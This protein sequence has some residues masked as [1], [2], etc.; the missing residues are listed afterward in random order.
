MGAG[1]TFGVALRTGMPS[2]RMTIIP[3]FIFLDTSLAASL[4]THLSSSLPS[5]SASY[6]RQSGSQ[7]A[8]G[9]GQNSASSS[10][11]EANIKTSFICS[12]N[13][14]RICSLIKHRVRFIV[15]K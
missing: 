1:G 14:L 7:H 6:T 4:S 10:A 9:S 11:S 15:V 12:S 3:N 5:Y 8:S 13:R 2:I